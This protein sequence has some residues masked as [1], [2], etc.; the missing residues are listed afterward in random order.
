MSTD[1]GAIDFARLGESAAQNGGDFARNFFGR[2]ANDV[3]RG[4]GA[5]APR[6][7]IRERVGR[8]D[9]AV[10]KGIIDNRREEI[11]GLDK[12]A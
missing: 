11:H 1:D 4:H 9:F 5:P 3:E 12:R 7:N 10:L 6:E 8:G 2:H